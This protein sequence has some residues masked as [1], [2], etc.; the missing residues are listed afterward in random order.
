MTEYPQ[1]LA[2]KDRIFNLIEM[3]HP[4][5]IAYE[6]LFHNPNND[7]GDLKWEWKFDVYFKLNGKEFAIEI[8]GWKGHWS[9][10]RRTQTKENIA[11]RH[12]KY[13]YLKDKGIELFC[14]PT[15]DLVGKKALPDSVFIEELHLKSMPITKEWYNE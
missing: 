11:K 15:K 8:D 6:Y 13:E 7:T 3:Y 12:F 5:T 1:H 10:K 14:F 4:E 9:K 2:A